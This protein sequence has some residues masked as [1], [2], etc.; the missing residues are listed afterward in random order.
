MIQYIEQYNSLIAFVGSVFTII[1][2]LIALYAIVI[3]RKQQKYSIELNLILYLEDNY[4]ILFTKYI[5]EFQWFLELENTIYLEKLKNYQDISEQDMSVVIREEYQKKTLA[6]AGSQYG[7][8]Y[9]LVYL[10][11]KRFFPVIEQYEYLKKSFL[12][13]EHSKSIEKINEQLK[14]QNDPEQIFKEYAEN[15]LNFKNN[16]I[17]IL[18]KLRTKL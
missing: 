9:E 13:E 12:D 8:K 5:E 3:W 7:R 6:D 16:G 17:S 15:F 4:E 18:E 2:A 1:A 14:K 11:A 10:R